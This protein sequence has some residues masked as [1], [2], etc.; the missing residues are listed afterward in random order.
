MFSACINKYL[1]CHIELFNS[2]KF[3]SESKRSGYLKEAGDSTQSQPCLASTRPEGGRSRAG[4]QSCCPLSLPG[5]PLVLRCSCHSSASCWGWCLLPTFK[6]RF[7]GPPWA[8]PLESYTSAH[9]APISCGP[10]YVLWHVIPIVWLLS[11][12][13]VFSLTVESSWKA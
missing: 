10:L 13:S 3:S 8:L 5:R 12:H 1:P 2:C 4:G 11:V 7:V 6:D 9:F